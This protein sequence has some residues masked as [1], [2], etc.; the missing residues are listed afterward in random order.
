MIVDD[1]WMPAIC[2][3]VS[4]AERNFGWTLLPAARTLAFRWRRLRNIPGRRL[5]GAGNVAVLRR[6]AARPDRRDWARFVPF[7]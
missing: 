1:L 5:R 7:T 4:Y 6:P 2:L 3:A